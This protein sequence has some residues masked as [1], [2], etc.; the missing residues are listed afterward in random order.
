MVAR[1]AVSNRDTIL[2][3][4]ST[5]DRNN[6]LGCPLDSSGRLVRSQRPNAV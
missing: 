1:G 4:A 2:A 3:L 5:P 6:N